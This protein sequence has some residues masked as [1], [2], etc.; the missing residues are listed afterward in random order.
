MQIDS[1]NQEINVNCENIESVVLTDTNRFTIN[2][3]VPH[4]DILGRVKT[5]SP[6]ERRVEDYECVEAPFL[7]KQ[8]ENIR[9]KLVNRSVIAEKQ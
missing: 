2:Y 1:K 4:T 3:F 7:V 9:N 5:E 8:F 6:M